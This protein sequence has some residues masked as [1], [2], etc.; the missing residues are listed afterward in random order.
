MPHISI[1]PWLPVGL[2]LFYYM[3]PCGCFFP[4]LFAVF[5]HELGHIAAISCVGGRITAIKLH[6]GG[7]VIQTATLTYSQEILCALSGPLTGLFFGLLLRKAQP[8]FWYWTA[9]HCIYNLLP[10]YPLDGGRALRAL[11]CKCIPLSKGEWLSNL[12][13]AVFYLFFTAFCFLHS[14]PSTPL[15]WRALPPL[16][17]LVQ[18]L[19]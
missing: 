6:I 2:C 7:A 15:L 17:L 11:L 18:V 14:F 3:D 1:S 8:W 13:S 19:S 10:I 9:L 5:V 12:V 4:F 16:F